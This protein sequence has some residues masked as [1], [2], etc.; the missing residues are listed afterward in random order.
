MADALYGTGCLS[1][2][3]K[4]TMKQYTKTIIIVAVVIAGIFLLLRFAGG[5]F[6]AKFSPGVEKTP[7]ENELE[8]GKAGEGLAAPYFDLVSLS[9]GHTSP[10]VSQGGRVR[11]AD[12][13]GNPVI[14]TF[15]ST[16]S[17]GSVDQ[18]KIFDDYLAGNPP[19][20]G[21]RSARIIA[22]DSQENQ[23]VVA[24]FMRRGGYDVEVLS[25]PTGETSGNYGVQTLPTTFFIDRDGIILE[26]FVG[27]LS[28]RMLVDK[29][30][31]ILR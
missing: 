9:G 7:G 6:V 10:N 20:D 26:I 13:L 2:T 17:S 19:S 29:M 14:L 5:S 3:M 27:T 31:K 4:T 22:I 30:E 25:D 1:G 15:W 18:I 11:R 24:N 8:N 16:W 21:V 23:S 28:E 12:L